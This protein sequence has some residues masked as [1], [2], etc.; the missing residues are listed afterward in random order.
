MNAPEPEKHTH[1]QYERISIDRMCL[2]QHWNEWHI[3]NPPF[4][5]ENRLFVKVRR[6]SPQSTFSFTTNE[7]Q[8][9]VRSAGLTYAPI[10]SLAQH[11]PIP[12]L[13]FAPFPLNIR[14]TIDNKIGS[15]PRDPF[16]KR[17]EARPH[18]DTRL[19]LSFIQFCFFCFDKQH[20]KME[21]KNK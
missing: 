19:I 15:Q 7:T 2:S 5:S 21:R 3:F 20:T 12:H 8:L 1:T 11:H 16:W 6:P 9:N 18:N 17:S 14:K 10:Y 13:R 4:E